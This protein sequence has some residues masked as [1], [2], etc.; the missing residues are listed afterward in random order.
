MKDHLPVNVS[1]PSNATGFSQTKKALRQKHFCLP[2]MIF[3]FLFLGIHTKV[4][5][6]H[7][8]FSDRG[9]PLI[10]PVPCNCTKWHTSTMVDSTTQ[11]LFEVPFTDEAGKRWRR[12]FFNTNYDTTLYEVCD[13][14]PM[15]TGATRTRHQY[16]DRQW[17]VDSAECTFTAFS[18]PCCIDTT[19][20]VASIASVTVTDGSIANISF[21]PATLSPSRLFA[22]SQ[23][24]VTATGCGNTLTATTTVV[25]SDKTGSFTPIQFNLSAYKNRLEN[26]LSTFLNGGVSPCSPSGSLFPSGSFG[27]EGSSICCPNAVPCVIGSRKYSGTATWSYGLKCHFPIF[28]CPYVASLDAV[29]S[30]GISGSVS[31]SAQTT[32]TA[33]KLCASTNV[34]LSVGGGLGFTLLGGLVAGDLQL[35]VSASATG[36]LCVYPTPVSLCGKI[37]VG[38][39][40]VVGTISAVW[41]IWDRTVDYTVFTGYT[42]PNWCTT[43]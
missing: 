18:L 13:E 21:T 7:I 31:I 37:N 8:F 5:G 28:G 41:G 35:V 24:T 42:T 32:C 26:V 33:V 14:P 30:A 1:K 17:S 27:Y 11:K 10:Q 16:G 12:I 40:K 9:T 15:C 6:Q 34:T 36:E 3:L 23:E 29:L 19:K 22:T 43:F 39:V 38:T 2:V 4:F 20:S 25:N